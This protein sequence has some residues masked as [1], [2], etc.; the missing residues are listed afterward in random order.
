MTV[1]YRSARI[2]EGR[3]RE[4]VQQMR[5]VEGA[6]RSWCQQG[7]KD[8]QRRSRLMENAAEKIKKC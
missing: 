3:N 4:Q 1:V 8:R 7:E 6:N 5:N 2:H